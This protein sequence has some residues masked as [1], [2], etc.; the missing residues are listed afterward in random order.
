MERAGGST[1]KRGSRRGARDA[2][3]HKFHFVCFA[4]RKQ[5]KRPAPHEVMVGTGGSHAR[6]GLLWIEYNALVS[7]CPQCRQTMVNL[8]R[9]FKPPKRSDTRGWMRLQATCKVGHE[10]LKSWSQGVG[11]V[12]TTGSEFA[13]YLSSRRRDFESKIKSAQNDPKLSPNARAEQVRHLSK[14]LAH[15]EREQA[16]IGKPMRMKKVSA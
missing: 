14:L 16:S 4:C 12:P 1:Y 5:F 6:R 13:D 2:M 8:G 11:F 10:W 15:V 7:R 3:V 9:D